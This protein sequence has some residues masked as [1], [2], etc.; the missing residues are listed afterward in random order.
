M[1]IMKLLKKQVHD[2]LWMIAHNDI[3]DIVWKRI[4]KKNMQRAQF[5]LRIELLSQIE[6]MVQHKVKDQID[7]MVVI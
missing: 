4:H 5:K 6:I 3:L 2:R 1:G 7:P